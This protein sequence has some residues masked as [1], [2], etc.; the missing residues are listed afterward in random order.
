MV[1]EATKW[2][3]YYSRI[4]SISVLQLR[5]KD[6]IKETLMDLV[7]E[8]TKWQPYHSRTVFSEPVISSNEKTCLRQLKREKKGYQMLMRL[9]LE[10]A[11]W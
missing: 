3:P 1:F 9:V 10:G 6:L 11:T 2:Q 4:T 5:Y 8:T 7:L